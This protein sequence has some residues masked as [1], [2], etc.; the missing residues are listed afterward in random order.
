MAK[1]VLDHQLS[2]LMGVP[3]RADVIAAVFYWSRNSEFQTILEKGKTTP[4]LS[5]WGRNFWGL[6][7]Y[8]GGRYSIS[9]QLHST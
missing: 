6:N 3:D 1:C 7:S 8:F 5:F 2:I 9:S 4:I